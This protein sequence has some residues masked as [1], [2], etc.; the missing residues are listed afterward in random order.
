M[1]EKKLTGYPSIDKPWLKYYKP[2]AANEPSPN[3]SL[4]D[5]LYENNK[6]RLEAKAINYFGRKLS[7]RTLFAEIEKAAKA[8]Q[9]IGV[10]PGDVVTLVMLTCV[11]AVACLYGLNRI[12]AVSNFV[13]VLASEDELAKYIQDGNSRIVVALDLFGSKVLTAAKKAG[14]EKVVFCSLTEFM[15]KPVKIG[16]MIKTVKMD[17]T[18]LKDSMSIR[19]KSFLEMGLGVEINEHECPDDICFYGHTGGTTGFPKTVLLQNKSFNVI[20]SNYLQ[21]FDHQVGDPLLGTI[22]IF[23][24]FGFLIGTHIPL[25]LGMQAVLLPKFDENGWLTYIRKYRVKHIAGVPAYFESMMEK[26]GDENLSQLVNLGIGGEGL[27]VTLEEKINRFISERGANASLIKGYGLSEVCAAAVTVYSWANKIGSVGIPLPKNVLMIYDNDNQQ[28]QT[29]N[30]T[31]EIC[32]QCA[33]VMVGYKDNPEE[34]EKLI[35]THPDGSRWIHTGDLGYIDEDGFLFVEGR[36]KRMIMTIYDGVVYKVFPAQIETELSRCTCVN[37]VCVVGDTDGNDRV[38]RAFV[39]ADQSC[40]Q[41]TAEIEAELRAYSEDNMSFYTR[42][43][44]YT[45]CESFPL[46]PAGK[47]DYRA[48]EKQIKP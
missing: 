21:Y 19:W 46:T 13:N 40:G 6:G 47:V 39:I 30:Q 26:L 41:S 29:Y 34:T 48:L 14:A 5:Y 23:V 11:P 28:E 25:C 15:P 31:G 37:G 8:F 45:F 12:G 9:A 24:T 32:M 18:F 4:Y 10:K 3:G 1:E 17:R 22:P 43:R 33:S 42:P 27:S 44:F 38:V 2:D 36:I 7:Y 35:Q 20:A 16:F